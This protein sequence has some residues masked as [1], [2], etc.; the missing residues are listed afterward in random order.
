MKRIEEINSI[1]SAH[2]DELKALF[3]VKKIG[4]FGSYARGEQNKKSDIDILV[5]F[6]GD[7]IGYF[8]YCDLEEYLKKILKVKKVDLVTKGALRPLIGK[9]ILSEVKY[10]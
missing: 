2:R 3:K 1:L 9:H 6:S 5:E 4:V 7:G 8:A 10:V